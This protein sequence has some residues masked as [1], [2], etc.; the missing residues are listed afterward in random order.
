MKN[1][2]KRFFTWSANLFKRVRNLILPQ[3]GGIESRMTSKRILPDEMRGNKVFVFGSNVMGNH[4]GGAAAFAHKFLGAPMGLGDGHIS[5]NA[6]AI[7]TLGYGFVQLPVYQLKRGI[8]AFISYA[9]R[10]PELDFYV[11]EVG[12]GIAGFKYHEIAPLFWE[13]KSISNI[14]LPATF[15][16]ILAPAEVCDFLTSVTPRKYV[17]PRDTDILIEDLLKIGY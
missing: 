1:S 3:T 9:K 5:K 14:H 8:E 10:H 4:V 11:T 13:A 15:W 16:A 17:F 12:C 6:Y 2:M 7:P